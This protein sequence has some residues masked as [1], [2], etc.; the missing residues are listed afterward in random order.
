MQNQL[1]HALRRPQAGFGPYRSE[2]GRG[3]AT[4]VG[5]ARDMSV[6]RFAEG[7]LGAVF[8]VERGELRNPRRGVA[9]VAQTRQAAMYLVHVGSGLTLTEVGAHFGRDRTTV[10]HGCR[11]IEERR[12]EPVFDQVMECL[13][14]ALKR[15]MSVFGEDAG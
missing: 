1:F 15:W 12:D 10:A 4:H 7:A 13:E 8:R 6:C 2:A 3:V 11:M 9:R 5:T 14:Y